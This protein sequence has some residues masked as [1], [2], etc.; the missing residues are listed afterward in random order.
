[1]TD[2]TTSGAARDLSG[3]ISTTPGDGPRIRRVDPNPAGG[4]DALYVIDGDFVAGAPDRIFTGSRADIPQTL[5]PAAKLRIFHVNDMHNHLF[6]TNEVGFTTQRLGQ[7]V[8]RVK[9]PTTAANPAATAL[10]LSAADNRRR[11]ALAAIVG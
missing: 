11:S 1:M 9:T 7:M 2:Q 3:V 8:H 5:P 4:I 10:F 6:D